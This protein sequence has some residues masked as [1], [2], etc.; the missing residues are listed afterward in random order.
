M[1]FMAA[2]MCLTMAACGDVKDGGTTG[3]EAE[4]P[5]VEAAATE[6]GAIFIMP[7]DIP[8]YITEAEERDNDAVN[9]ALESIQ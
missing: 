1:F 2:A 6:S 5:E 9:V 3:G 4:K 7:L 8:D